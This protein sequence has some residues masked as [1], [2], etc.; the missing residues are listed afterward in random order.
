MSRRSSSAIAA[1]A[2]TA[3]SVV[4]LDGSNHHSSQAQK[5]DTAA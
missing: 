1:D 5:S 3:H 4:R 2:A